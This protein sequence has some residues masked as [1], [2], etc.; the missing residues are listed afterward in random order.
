MLPHTTTAAQIPHA[1]ADEGRSQP[2]QAR[3]ELLA[4]KATIGRQHKAYY[5]N[6]DAEPKNQQPIAMVDRCVRAVQ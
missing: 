6:K 2:H 4:V 5:G 1:A 3:P